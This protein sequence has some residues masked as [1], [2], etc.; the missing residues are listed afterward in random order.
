MSNSC[1]KVLLVEDEPAYADL[2]SAMLT[3][4]VSTPFALTHVP[5]FGAAEEKLRDN[6][7]DIILLD[8]TLPDRTG[9]NTYADMKSLAPGVPIVV[10]TGCDD[11]KVGLQA[12]R[13]GAQDYLLKGEFDGKLL[14]RVIRYAIER[15]RAEKDLRQREE[16][17]RLITENMHDLVIVLDRE[18]LLLYASP[19]CR[20]LLGDLERMKGTSPFGRIHPQDL[21]RTMQ[22]FRESV[23]TGLGQRVEYRLL[24]PSGQVRHIDSQGSVIL[25]ENRKAC[26]VVVVSRDVTERKEAVEVLRQALSDLKKSHE[27]LKATQV[28]LIQAE[29]LEAVS[30]FAAGVAHEVKNPLQTMIL[31]LDYLNHHGGLNDPA[32]PDVIADMERAVQHAD[33]IIRGLMEFSSYRKREVKEEDLNAIL[34]QALPAVQSDIIN[35]RICLVKDLGEGLPKLRVD[36]RTMKHVFINLFAS[37]IREMT[38]GGNLA[39]RTYM[40]H[41]GRTPSP[42]L[43]LPSHFKP[44]DTVVVA[45][46]EE[47]RRK[48]W[49]TDTLDAKA[50][51][52][53]SVQNGADPGGLGLTV[54]K[55]IV[56]LHGGII[57]AVKREPGTN[58]FTIVFRASKQPPP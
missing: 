10:L 49:E 45:E 30:T 28:Q 50:P 53:P 5:Q 47:S 57:D 9:L 2:H 14:A 15:K 35:G 33:G 25:D 17:F 11:D 20:D 19:S 7:F 37:A 3:G 27:E 43:K 29:R 32:A 41:L 1:I 31:G 23:A 42:N 18:G 40:H 39:V 48:P 21:G 4:G 52:V 44:D 8:L 24:T 51:R 13:D 26:K 16:F 12:V 22:A 36:P 55:K 34:E 54:L 38:D 46:V 56:E 58:K 6:N